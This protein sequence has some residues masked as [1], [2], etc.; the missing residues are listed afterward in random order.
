MI[1]RSD[2]GGS[3]P[4]FMIERGTPGG[5]IGDASKFLDWACSKDIDEFA[6]DVP[7]DVD[8]AS[9]ERSTESGKA[10][11]HEFQTNGHLAGL[12]V[13]D[14]A[15]SKGSAQHPHPTQA[16]SS[17]IF[18]YLSGAAGAAGATLAAYTP[19][20]VK[21]HMPGHFS[22]EDEEEDG[23]RTPIA[24]KRRFSSS[25]GSSTDSFASATTGHPNMIYADNSLSHRDA[26]TSSVGTGAS[27]AVRKM[28]SQ[29]EK[30]LQRLEDKKRKL[31]EKL[32]KEKEREL[33]KKN[34]DSEKEAAALKKAE[35][36]HQKDV[37][38]Q[39]EKYRKEVQK[40]E[41]KK[42]KEIQ[43]AEAKKRKEL[44]KDE[45][46]KLSR[47]L[48]QTKAELD[49][50]NKEREILRAQV[51]DLQRENTALAAR[52]GKGSDS[53]TLLEEVR[54]ETVGKGG[55]LQTEALSGAKASETSA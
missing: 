33:A 43:K 34:E 20:V 37:E 8:E 51:G 52:I 53:A 44:E 13:D 5:I 17:G 18:S 27:A 29:A 35:E 6:K 2:P 4:R 16:Q 1:T 14:P 25:S 10:Q 31:D 15:S 32:Q 47:E 30:E 42:E 46:V 28:D 3:V 48:E 19:Q 41:Q 39:E 45:K 22:E 9:G 21:S 12:N 40:L 49:V 55:V 50:A 54:L 11:I 36:K 24:E 7:E 38:K 26:D 23:G